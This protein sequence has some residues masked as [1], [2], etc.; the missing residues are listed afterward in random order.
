MNLISAIGLGL[1]IAGGTI[2]AIGLLGAPWTLAL[3]A[4]SFL[5]ESAPTAVFLCESRADAE[6]GIPALVL[7]F[8]GQLIGLAV[9]AHTW[10]LIGFLAA[11]VCAVG[12]LALWRFAW[13][14]SRTKSLA[15]EVA[16]YWV[17]DA[18]H[19][20]ERQGKPII[21]RLVS[22]APGLGEPVQ[23]PEENAAYVE[24]VFGITETIG[25]NDLS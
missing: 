25:L 21:E 18:R 10:V 2:I 24:R 20:P 13:R 23:E 22:M 7:G 1:D 8:G 5:G 17:P 12:T 3:R 14:P 19:R 11:A 6:V 16:H 4:T 9:S 15:I